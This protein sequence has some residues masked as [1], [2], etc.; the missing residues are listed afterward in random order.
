VK[1]TIFITQPV[2]DSVIQT[3]SQHCLVKRNTDDAP[4]A[5]EAL[6]AA[7]A[8]CHGVLTQLNDRMDAEAM[9]R[10]PNLRVISNIAV[11]Y[12]NIDV[13][14]A[15]ARRIL[16]TN[17]PGILTD[18]TADFAFALLLAAARRIIE[19]DRFARSGQ[20]KRWKLDL[21]LGADV[22]HAT[23]GI[24]GLGRIGQAMARR[25]RGFSMPIL[26]SSPRRAAPEVEQELAARHVP[27]ETL[28]GE[29]DFVSLHVPLKSDT[30][31]LIAAPELALMKPTAIL[32]NT[33]RGPVVH[34][35]DLVAALRQGRIQAAAL[36]VFENEPEI[37]PGLI[38]LD[39]VVLAPHSGSGSR[40]TRLRMVEV[41]AQNL[42]AALRGDTPPNLLNPAARSSRGTEE[43]S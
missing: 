2:F 27:L 23:L 41:A 28:L 24:V 34:E 5:R 29:S 7:L 3:L 10:A 40:Q 25:A 9:D 35:G 15:T 31:H 19:S 42:L 8:D 26:Y 4:P 16:V 43:R 33:T 18:T 22:H 13:S 38:G 20:W 30:R 32:I 11:G 12:D 6:Y 37:H 17:T 14:A 1:P 21:L 36:D 39:N